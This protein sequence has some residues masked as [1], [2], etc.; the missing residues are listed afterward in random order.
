MKMSKRNY[1]RFKHFSDYVLENASDEQVGYLM[2][3]LVDACDYAARKCKQLAN[4]Q[5]MINKAKN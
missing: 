1:L 3:V 4:R 2:D 5:K